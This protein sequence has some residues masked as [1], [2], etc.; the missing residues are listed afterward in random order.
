MQEV[1]REQLIPGKEY[2]LQNFESVFLPPRKSYKMIA[3]FTPFFI[4]N[5]DYLYNFY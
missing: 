4:S 1:P 3:K 2:Y 5:A